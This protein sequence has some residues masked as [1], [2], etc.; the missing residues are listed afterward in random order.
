MRVTTHF[1]EGTVG[2]LQDCPGLHAAVISALA[3]G[4]PSLPS[5]LFELNAIFS[6]S[7]IDLKRVS[8]IIR[9]DPSLSAQ[10][11]RTCYALHGESLVRRGV[12]D[13]ILLLGA[14]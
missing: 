2:N 10:V 8:Q 9:T 5:Y 14:D 6:T 11:I 3:E 12:E 1:T 13:A 4:I 7:P